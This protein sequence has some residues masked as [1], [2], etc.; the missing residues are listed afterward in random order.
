M[1]KVL[2]VAMIT[3]ALAVNAF[4]DIAPQPG[5][6]PNRVKKPISIATDMEIRLD[7][8]ATEARLQIPAS[9]LKELRA[10]LDS[11][12]TDPTAAG[13]AGSGS[14]QIPTIVAGTLLSLAFVFGGF[15]IVRNRAITISP[16]A[17][18]AIAVVAAA[19]AGATLVYANV[20]PPAEAR[21]ITGKMF[22]Q[23]VHIYGFGYGKVKIELSDDDR[24][25]LI[26]PNQK[27]ETKPG[28]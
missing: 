3:A 5:K 10:E 11:L 13:T 21:S 14:A 8:L 26:V 2:F 25:K 19:A 7:P 6:S 17:V 18:G 24:I 12:D 4:A 1:N 22:T 15:W 16:R 27:T 28:E 23:A 20:G 9:R